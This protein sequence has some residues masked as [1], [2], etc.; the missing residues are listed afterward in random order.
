MNR[1][2][3]IFDSATMHNNIEILKFLFEYKI[4]AVFVPKGLTYTLS[5]RCINKSC[6]QILDEEKIL[7]YNVFF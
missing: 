7:K 5:L 6:F 1:S 3:L 2:L 4:N